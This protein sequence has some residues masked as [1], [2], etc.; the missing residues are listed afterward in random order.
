[1]SNLTGIFNV[2]RFQTAFYMVL[3][4]IKKRAVSKHFLVSIL[5]HTFLFRQKHS[6]HISPFFLSSGFP[7]FTEATN[8][9]PLV[10][11]GNLFSLPLIPLTAMTK[12]F[13]APVL[14]AQFI[15]APTGRAKEILNFPPTR[16]PAKNWSMKI[17]KI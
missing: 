7:F 12:R 14:S 10:A 5:A 4:Y 3:S 9:S 16:P 15:T 17:F 13:F 2:S 6:V 8:M 11:V 1:M